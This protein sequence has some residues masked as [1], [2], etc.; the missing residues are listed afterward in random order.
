[1]TREPLIRTG[2][3]VECFYTGDK[4][5]R[6]HLSGYVQEGSKGVV[7]AVSDPNGYFNRHWD[8]CVYWYSGE[9]Y[10][11]QADELRHCEGSRT[12]EFCAGCKFS[13]ICPHLQEIAHCDI[14]EFTAKFDP[15]ACMLRK[16]KL[17]DVCLTHRWLQK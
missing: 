7:L 9:R 13:S 1:M 3:P 12:K 5:Y 6:R 16:C 14:S 10:L 11:H 8:Y 4:C 2:D 15:D 17:L